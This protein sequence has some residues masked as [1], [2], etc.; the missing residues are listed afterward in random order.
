MVILRKVKSATLI[1]TLIATVL[2]VIVFLLSAMIINSIFFNTFHQKKDIVVNRLD[3]LEYNCIN[4]SII[5]PYQEE[6][7]NWTI[8]ID[9]KKN[10]KELKIIAINKTTGKEIERDLYLLANE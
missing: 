3:E 4:K 5:L 6:Y 1:E 10:V 7:E 2:I 8:Q 9:K